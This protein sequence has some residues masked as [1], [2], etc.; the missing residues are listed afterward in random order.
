MG[1]DDEEV[2]AA[3]LEVCQGLLVYSDLDRKKKAVNLVNYAT[4]LHVHDRNLYGDFTAAFPLKVWSK[5]GPEEGGTETRI[6]YLSDGYVERID[7]ALKIER[8]ISECSAGVFVLHGKPGI[9]KSA[10]VARVARRDVPYPETGEEN[11]TVHQA[12]RVAVVPFFYG[13]SISGRDARSCIK[14]L[15]EA[16]E[17]KFNLRCRLEG[18]IDDLASELASQLRVLSRR[19]SQERNGVEKV[20]L[21]VDGLDEALAS[22]GNDNLIKLLDALPRTLPDGILLLI[23]A[24]WRTEIQNFYSSVEARQRYKHEVQPLDVDTARTM[25]CSVLSKYDLADHPDYVE[26]VIRRSERLPLY[27]EMLATDIRERRIPLYSAEALP[28]GVEEYFE[29]T[30]RHLVKTNDLGQKTL[31]VLLT[32][33]IAVEPLTVARVACLVGLDLVTAEKLIEQCAEVL[34]AEPGPGKKITYGVFHA[35]FGEYLREH[36]HYSDQLRPEVEKRFLLEP[37]LEKKEAAPPDMAGRVARLLGSDQLGAP[38]VAT[39]GA[40]LDSLGGRITAF[41]LAARALER[42]SVSDVSDLLIGLTLTAGRG[43]EDAVVRRLV[44]GLHEDPAKILE[45]VDRLAPVRPQP[46]P[47]DDPLRPLRVALEVAASALRIYC[48]RDSDTF[49]VPRAMDVVYRA[50]CSSDTATATLGTMALY[51]TATIDVSRALDVVGQLADRMLRWRLVRPRAVEPFACAALGLFF[52]NAADKKVT[53]RLHEITSRVLERA[54]GLRLAA[55]ILPPLVE[56]FLGNIASDYNALNLMEIKAAKLLLRDNPELRAINT[57]LINLIDPAAGDPDELSDIIDRLIANPVE[58]RY[59]FCLFPLGSST[60]SQT[61]AHGEA[62]LEAAWRYCEANRGREVYFSQSL[63]ADIRFV[64]VGLEILDKAPLGDVW[65][66]RIDGTLRSFYQDCAC[67][68]HINKPYYG[69][70]MASGLLF[71][72]QQRGDAQLEV[73]RDLVRDACSRS[74][75]EATPRQHHRDSILLRMLEVD[76]IEYGTF[77][78]LGVEIALFG[79]KCFLDH[80]SSA[81]DDRWRRIAKILVRL[82]T[83]F[84][85]KVERF[86][87]ELDS[88]PVRARLQ[89][90]MRSARTEESVGTLLGMKIEYFNVAAYA[91]PVDCRDGLRASWQ[92]YQRI[93]YS[94]TSLRDTLKSLVM[95]ILDLL[96]RKNGDA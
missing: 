84:P 39:I 75:E 13:H 43:S 85:E 56:R 35:R 70:Y 54:L 86:L 33:A 80:A 11:D 38:D 45:V 63:L 57:Q 48:K 40:L 58:P 25:L 68:F 20:L 29:R 37:W 50:C 62:A 55:R 2:R 92:E 6:E 17:R 34:T 69:G 73:L 53:G 21:L 31:E 76:G 41:E 7:D 88:P 78:P 42:R 64:Q 23:S 71:L 44:G 8:W 66:E 82:R 46:G 49:V 65:S 18:D 95:M 89:S 12:E 52:E 91:E 47:P 15:L 10:L 81:D 74:D 90:E 16:M 28:Q 26:A 27:L 14:G 96:I 59:G 30:V 5:Q 32:F 24:R 51:R 1:A 72:A 79:L 3:A 67:S 4:G 77:K 93:L 19:L 83:Y 60:I 94:P 22:G 36:G 61:L 87:E 9:G